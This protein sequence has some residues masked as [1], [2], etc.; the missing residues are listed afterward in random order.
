[1]L[2]I[3][4]LLSTAS[5]AEWGLKIEDYIN[6]LDEDAAL[7]IFASAAVV[8]TKQC[9]SDQ[10]TFHIDKPDLELKV[11]V[12]YLGPNAPLIDIDYLKFDCGYVITSIIFC[13]LQL[14]IHKLTLRSLYWHL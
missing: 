8:E 10:D 13:A 4:V 14:L 11:L 9:F 7:G 1:M 12:T 5:S 2:I 6:K 3:R